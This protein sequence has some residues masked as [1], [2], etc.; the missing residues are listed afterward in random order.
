MADEEVVSD[1]ESTPT[2]TDLLTDILNDIRYLIKS[3][4]PNSVY[5]DFE[6]PTDDE[7]EG[8]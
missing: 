7:S 5:V 8:E 6:Y 1:E 3:V 2:E 4:V